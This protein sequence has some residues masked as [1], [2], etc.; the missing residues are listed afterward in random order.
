MEKFIR[1]L[2]QV[3]RSI[4]VEGDEILVQLGGIHKVINGLSYRIINPKAVG[5]LKKMSSMVY[6]LHY[7]DEDDIKQETLLCILLSF[8]EL[9]KRG[10][11]SIEE[12]INLFMINSNSEVADEVSIE[13][14]RF[15]KLL[16][17]MVKFHL[18][19]IQNYKQTKIST[20]IHGEEIKVIPFSNFINEDSEE[21]MEEMI[22]RINILNNQH[23]EESVDNTLLRWLECK[24]VELTKGEQ[25]YLIN[26]LK[27]NPSTRSRYQKNI[28]KKISEVVLNEFGVSK[29]KVVKDII[30]F[31]II[32]KILS[33][34]DFQQSIVNN[35]EEIEDLFYGNVENFEVLKD[36]TQAI[37][38]PSYVCKDRNLIVLS[39]ILWSKFNYLKDKLKDVYHLDREDTQ[40]KVVDIVK[41]K[42]NINLIDG[43]DTSDNDKF[44][45]TIKGV[46]QPN[47]AKFRN[48]HKKA[49][50][51]NIKV[52]GDFLSF[53]KFCEWLEENRLNGDT[54]YM[55]HS[56]E[57]EYNHENTYLLPN[58]LIK[59]LKS[60]SVRF[61][62]GE[63]IWR[64][65]FKYD[66]KAY[67]YSSIDNKE[68]LEK[69]L[70]NIKTLKLK[71][72]AE[73]NKNVLSGRS[74]EFLANHEF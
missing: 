54:G 58:S 31:K 25:S 19:T 26:P 34:D 38:N 65:E 57:K 30:L 8:L 21:S 20:A 73:E 48:M 46:I 10:K 69:K 70:K 66:G 39:G 63:N 2:I 47:W 1:E 51:E 59:F 41:Q 64:G 33:A 27:T 29:E 43:I 72:I 52:S 7:L 28:E 23:L 6:R 61:I 37:N 44:K 9:E 17:K 49:F 50:E 16:E 40:V 32:D 35:I 62:K 3:K 42:F 71:E 15:Y 36:L 55:Y 14:K 12:C 4:D 67:S 56:N 53:I 45:R 18:A 22:D 74:F 5:L 68:G 13:A 11:Y 60:A 24:K